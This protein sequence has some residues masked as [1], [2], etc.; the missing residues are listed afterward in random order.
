[1]ETLR[2]AIA[3]INPVVGDLE[4]NVDLIKFALEKLNSDLEDYC[5]KIDLIRL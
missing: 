3:Q 4:G 5:K 1:M 2:L